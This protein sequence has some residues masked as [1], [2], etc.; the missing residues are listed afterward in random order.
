MPYGSGSL[1]SGRGR[2]EDTVDICVNKVM[3]IQ[4]EREFGRRPGGFSRTG[5]YECPGV[6]PE[7][8]F[9]TPI[10]WVYETRERIPAAIRVILDSI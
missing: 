5:C 8:P 9:Q 6:K 7:C 3:A 2:G 4:E 10:S 1:P